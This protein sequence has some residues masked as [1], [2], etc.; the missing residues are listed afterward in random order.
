M[1]QGFKL[2]YFKHN[3][4]IGKQKVMASSRKMGNENSLNYVNNHFKFNCVN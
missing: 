1:L 3:K 4:M 2:H